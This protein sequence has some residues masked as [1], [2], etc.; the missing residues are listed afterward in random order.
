MRLPYLLGLVVLLTAFPLAC[1]GPGI[2]VESSVGFTHEAS[3][4]IGIAGKINIDLRQAIAKL[5][6]DVDQFTTFL[7][8]WQH[9]LA[10]EVSDPSIDVEQNAKKADELASQVEQAATVV[11]SSAANVKARDIG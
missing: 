7:A 5:M 3:D 4:I 9:T 10:G 8:E 6:D 1:A 2:S 11:L